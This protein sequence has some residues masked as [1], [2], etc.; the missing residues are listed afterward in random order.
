MDLEVE[1]THPDW[2]PYGAEFPGWHVWEGVNGQMYARRPRSSP[3]KV[4]R[5]DTV[6]GLRDGIIGLDIPGTA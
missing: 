6:A 5:A 1:M 3:A 4:A 2:W